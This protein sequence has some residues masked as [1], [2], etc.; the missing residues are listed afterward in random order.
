MVEVIVVFRVGSKEFR[1]SFFDANQDVI[2]DFIG[3]IRPEHIVKV[4]EKNHGL[5]KEDASS[6]K[7]HTTTKHEP[8]GD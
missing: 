5:Q 4:V 7:D 3:R 6:I 8:L 2:D 1:Q